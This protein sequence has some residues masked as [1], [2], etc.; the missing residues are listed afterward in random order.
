MCVL[1]R[2]QDSGSVDSTDAKRV[3]QSTDAFQQQGNSVFLSPWLSCSLDPAYATPNSL[4]ECYD[5]ACAPQKGEEH[6]DGDT[7]VRALQGLH[8]IVAGVSFS[9]T[10]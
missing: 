9:S 10:G 8:G 5:V 6:Q 4:H 1:A 3:Q 7:G 2:G